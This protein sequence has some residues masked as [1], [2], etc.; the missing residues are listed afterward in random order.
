MEF[1]E[2]VRRRRMV[3][4]YTAEPVDPQALDRI[5]DTGRHAPSA[6]FAQAQSFVVV[7]EARTRDD[8][9]RLCGEQ[10]AVARGLP[11]WL[12]TAPVHVIPCVRPADYVERY[13]EADKSGSRPPA[14]W[15]V[16]WWWV[17]AG[18]ALLLLLLAA[19]DEGLAAGLLDV[20]RPEELRALLRIP[21]D[22]TP[23]GVV[24]IG[25]GAPDRRS[26][27]LARGRRPRSDTVHLGL[28]GQPPAGR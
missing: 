3:R 20:T 5:L 8:I 7:S 19:V 12:S 11:R 15:D 28:W 16:P 6:G 21:P 14:D 13:A 9:S 4:A 18:Q 26:S 27:S 22:V 24:T 23:L 25:H 17:D 1:A 10:E 2:V